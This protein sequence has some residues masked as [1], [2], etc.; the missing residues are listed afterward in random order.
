MIIQELSPVDWGKWKYCCNVVLRIVPPNGIV[1][2]VAMKHNSTFVA[3]WINKIF[4]TRLLETIHQRILHSPKITVW[5]ALSTWSGWRHSYCDFQSVLR[6]IRKLFPPISRKLKS[7]KIL[8][9]FGFNRMEPQLIRPVILA[10][11]WKKCFLVTW[12]SKGKTFHGLLAP[13]I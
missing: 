7:T 13:L 1:W 10:Q 9:P 3:Q 12:S 6:D 2:S 8:M 5:C 11:F 4:I